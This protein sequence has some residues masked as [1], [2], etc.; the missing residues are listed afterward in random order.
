MKPGVEDTD[1]SAVD[2]DFDSGEVEGGYGVG[3]CERA[4]D[5][6]AAV[7]AEIVGE[8]PVVE[9][10][11]VGHHWCCAVGFDHDNDVGAAMAENVGCGLACLLAVGFAVSAVPNVPGE[12]G[13]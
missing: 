9:S 13:E 6:I 11:G 1:D 7:D 5:G 12:D 10:E 3:E 2:I 4:H 8:G